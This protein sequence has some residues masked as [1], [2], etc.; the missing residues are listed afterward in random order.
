MKGKERKKEKKAKLRNALG[1]HIEWSIAL[2]YRL[3][4]LPERHDTRYRPRNRER[5]SIPSSKQKEEEGV[6][7]ETW[8]THMVY[9]QVQT[10]GCCNKRVKW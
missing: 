9:P 10:Y 2:Y 3:T 7:Y 6:H 4:E 1:E 5:K 8:N